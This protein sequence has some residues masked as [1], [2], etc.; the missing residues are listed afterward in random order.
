MN[1]L[2]PKKCC[3]LRFEMLPYSDPGF[4]IEVENCSLQIKR[5]QFVPNL[6]LKQSNMFF[7][8]ADG[9]IQ[10]WSPTCLDAQGRNC[11]Q[12]GCASPLLCG[13]SQFLTPKTR[14]TRYSVQMIYTS[15]DSQRH[16]GW[17]GCMPGWGTLDSLLVLAAWSWWTVATQAGCNGQGSGVSHLQSRGSGVVTLCILAGK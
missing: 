11:Y 2:C 7:R 10:Q 6:W 5:I 15:Q 4:Q 1:L 17:D 14:Q 3:E 9:Q 16:L 12:L 13:S 8:K